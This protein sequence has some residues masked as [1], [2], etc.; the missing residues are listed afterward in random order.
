MW[1]CPLCPREVADS[2]SGCAKGSFWDPAGASASA[3]AAV[4]NTFPPTSPGDV[5]RSG[6]MSPSQRLE[7]IRNRKKNQTNA[8]TVSTL[9]AILNSKCNSSSTKRLAS[10]SDRRKNGN[11]SPKKGSTLEK[12]RRSTGE[13]SNAQKHPPAEAC[14]S[15]V[16]IGGTTYWTKD[17]MKLKRI[18]DAMEKVS[19]RNGVVTLELVEGQGFRKGYSAFRFYK[20][21]LMVPDSMENRVRNTG[22]TFQELLSLY[23]PNHSADEI[24]LLVNLIPTE[25]DIHLNNEDLMY[26]NKAWDLWKHEE[27]TDDLRTHEFVAVLRILG[28]NKPEETVSRVMEKSDKLKTGIINKQKFINWWFG[29]S[30]RPLFHLRSQSSLSLGSLPDQASY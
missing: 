10:V 7:S 30:D 16:E 4:L 29:K 11:V 2:T 19:G 14:S 20:K 26:F 22:V 27:N 21:I 28:V 18:F 9:T 1:L 24:L 23:Y 6:S 25:V 5:S 8:A 12:L 3:S 15:K 13:L 17:L